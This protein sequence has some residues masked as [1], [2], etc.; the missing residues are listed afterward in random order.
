MEQGRATRGG[1]GGNCPPNNFEI[2]S[3]KMEERKKERK[4]ERERERER[5]GKK[6]RK[7]Y[8]EI[9]KMEKEKDRK[10]K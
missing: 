1:R 10:E 4:K 7:R 9:L 2:C 3:L 8:R 6:E 5:E